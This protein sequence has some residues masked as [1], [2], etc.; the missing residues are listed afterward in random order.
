MS[1]DLRPTRAP[2]GREHHRRRPPRLTRNRGSPGCARDPAVPVG[3][4]R[5]VDRAHAVRWLRGRAAVLALVPEHVDPG[6]AGLRDRPADPQDLRGRRAAAGR[7]RVPL[8]GGDVTK[9]PAVRA[10][11]ARVAA[12]NPGALTSSFFSTGSAAYVSADRHT[13]FQEVYLPGRDGVDR[14]SGAVEMRAVAA[15][16][17]PAG[18]HGRRD[19]PH[20]ARRGEHPRRRRI[21]RAAGGTHRRPRRAAGAAVRVRDAAGGAHAARR[22][23][24]GDPQH[25]HARLGADLRHRR[26]DHRAVPDR[27]GRP[28][29]RDRLRP[30]DDLP[31]P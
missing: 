30:V 11:M 27:A 7:R 22:R 25:V 10:A 31:V 15:A 17:L 6:P 28:R 23:G 4:D 14:K 29:R 3:G 12:A 24:S 21:E 16:G 9:I 1:T 18:R 19:R 8:A 5:R 2:L 13:T 20:R 26:L